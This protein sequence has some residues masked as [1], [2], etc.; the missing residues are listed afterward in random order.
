MARRWPSVEPLER[1]RKKVR[2][3]ALLR[4]VPPERT[5]QMAFDLIRMTRAINEATQDADA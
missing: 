4:D 2:E 5:L 1:A 3:A